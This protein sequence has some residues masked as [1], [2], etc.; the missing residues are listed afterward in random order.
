MD[1]IKKY[2]NIFLFEGIVFALLGIFAIALPQFS[3]LAIELFIGWTFLI[4]GFVQ[5]Y[6]SLTTYEAVGFWPSFLSAGLTILS[7]ALLL[8]YPLSGI[9]TLTLILTL[10]F[11][12]DGISKLFLA[13]QYRTF[14]H[15]SWVFISGLLSLILATIIWF[16]WPGTASW[17]MGLLV[18]VNML[19]FG[20]A[21]L[22]FYFSSK[23]PS[24]NE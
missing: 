19:M 14:G 20:C 5:G 13:F 1:I 9:L 17:V 7:G 18:G 16:G 2:Q 11:F 3:T 4:A 23:K 24:A 22:A 21:M 8:I 12:L 10:F 15:G 6:R